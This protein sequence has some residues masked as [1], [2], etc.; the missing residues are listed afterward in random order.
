[1]SL[2]GRGEQV[3]NGRGVKGGDWLPVRWVVVYLRPNWFQQRRAE[4]IERG[5]VTGGGR[6]RQD[7]QATGNKQQITANYNSDSQQPTRRQKVFS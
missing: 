2:M 6:D 3:S 5:L 1:M 4:K 7:Q